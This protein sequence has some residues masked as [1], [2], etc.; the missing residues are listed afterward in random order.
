MEAVHFGAG[1]I[2]RGFIGQLLRE[3]GYGVTF[4]DIQDAVVEA[5]KSQGRYEVILA[6]EEG[7]RI[8]VEGVTALH[9]VEEAEAVVERLATAD[10]VTTAVGPSVLT[11]LAPALAQGLTERAKR[12]GEPVNVVACENMIGGSQ[13][14]REYVLENAADGEA[15][16]G[17][18]GFPN[19]AVD[20][21]VPEQTTS[22]IDVLVEPFYEWVVDASQV[23]GQRPEVPGITYVEAIGPYI[24]RKLLT[25]NTGHATTAYLGY[26]AGKR[27]IDEALRDRHVH[28]MATKTLEET[29]TLL[30]REHGFD[31]EEHAGYRRKVLA[32][33]ENPRISDDVARVARTPIRKL[34][35]NE[36]FVS[37]A[38]RLLGMGERPV[39]LATVIGAVLRYDNPDDPEARELQE[40]VKAEGQ[41]AAFAWCAGIE[42][43]HPLADLVVELAS[44]GGLE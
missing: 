23:A 26:A 5:L 27:T 7:T 11:I 40:R 36:R 1:N 28:D 12:G 2:G 10:L 31:P 42:E 44:G 38:L 37:P 17:V 22:G 8:L 35:P 30:V 24:E 15:I 16:D 14:L 13:A 32:R 39:H 4:V 3:A 9:S 33:F 6:D 20:R 29:G 19:A 41:R 21:I 25:V 18:A 43:D 34:G